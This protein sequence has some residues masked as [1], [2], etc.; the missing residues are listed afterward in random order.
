M[1]RNFRPTSL[2]SRFLANVRRHAAV[3]VDPAQTN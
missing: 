2:F 3:F 1:R